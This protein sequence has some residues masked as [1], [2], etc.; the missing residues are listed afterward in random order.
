MSTLRK[1]L[2]VCCAMCGSVVRGKGWFCS[3]KCDEMEIRFRRSYW[4]AND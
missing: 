1:Y 4:H 3:F 2:Q